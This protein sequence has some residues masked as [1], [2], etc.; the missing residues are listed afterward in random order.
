M[1]DDAVVIVVV[2]GVFVVVMGLHGTGDPSVLALERGRGLTRTL[3]R[4]VG[5]AAAVKRVRR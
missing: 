1:D 5:N 2:A 4:S 3:H